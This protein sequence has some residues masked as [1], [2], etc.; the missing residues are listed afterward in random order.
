MQGFNHTLTGVALGVL[1]PEPALVAPVALAS[2]FALDVIPHYG[3]HSPF[4]LGDKYYLPK[5]AADIFLSL[6]IFVVA[7]HHFPG[8]TVAITTGVVFSL[9][10][11]VLWPFNLV[12]KRGPLKRFL[13]WHKAIQWSETGPGIITEL[14]YATLLVSYLNKFIG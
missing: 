5:I 7:Q 13:R 1:I 8:H 11:D 14:L 4:A 9:L 3:E 10:P 12:V 2:H 6:L